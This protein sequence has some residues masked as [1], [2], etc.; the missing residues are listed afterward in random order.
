MRPASRRTQ[1]ETPVP[2]EP[3]LAATRKGSRAR[4]IGTRKN[5]FDLRRASSIQNLEAMHRAYLEAHAAAPGT[6]Q[7]RAWHVSTQIQVITSP[8]FTSTVAPLK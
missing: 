8:P 3:S 7:A 4:Y 5:L 6:C 2:S 1:P